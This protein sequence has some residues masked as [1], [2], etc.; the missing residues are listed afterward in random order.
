M[1]FKS[2]EG[3]TCLSFKTNL[4]HSSLSKDY[5]ILI[6]EASINPSYYAKNA[7]PPEKSSSKKHLFLP[8]KKDVS[9]FQDTII[10]TAVNLRKRN[11]KEQHIFPGQIEIGNKD[12]QCV[13]LQVDD[14]SQFPELLKE[15]DKYNIKFMTDSKVEPYESNM[16]FKK[17]IHFRN[18]LDDV[19]V[20]ANNQ[21]RYFFKI[22]KHIDFENF[23]KGIEKIKRNCDYHLFDSFLAHLFKN[24]EVLDFIGIYSKHCD[25]S[26]FDELKENIRIVF[27]E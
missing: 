12:H 5:G 27:Q 22:D 21:H 9:C 6:L 7:F 23:S 15:L 20:D 3:L 10:R 2:F 24:D 25:E 17:H 19:Y 14:L 1:N 26:R 18:I 16:Y 8:V 11:N 13:H 4:Y